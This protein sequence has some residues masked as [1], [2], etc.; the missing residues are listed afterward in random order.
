MHDEKWHFVTYF[1]K[2][3]TSVEQNYDIHDKK[4]LAIVTALKQWKIN[5]KEAFSLTVYTNHK[6]LI[7]FITIKQFNW[8]QIRWSELLNQY[9]LKIVY[10]LK[11]GNDSVDT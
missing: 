11:K 8:K 1:S 2:K 6:N 10:I 5:T 4:L 3:S 9:K 7:T